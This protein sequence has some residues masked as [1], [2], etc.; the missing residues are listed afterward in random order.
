MIVLSHHPGIINGSKLSVYSIF[1]KLYLSSSLK[2]S[3]EPMV[4]VIY[5]HLTFI[6]TQMWYIWH[7]EGFKTFHLKVTEQI[8][9]Y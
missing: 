5:N 3:T 7:S 6:F 9:I 2:S 4:H 1:Q 8:G